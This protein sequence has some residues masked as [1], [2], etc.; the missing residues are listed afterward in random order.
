MLVDALY[1]ETVQAV[2]LADE[3]PLRLLQLTEEE[4][5]SCTFDEIFAFDRTVSRLLEMQSASYLNKA[6]AKSP[7]PR[8][9]LLTRL[10][11]AAIDA[12]ARFQSPLHV[13]ASLDDGPDGLAAVFREYNWG[14]DDLL[15]GESLRVLLLDLRAAL[16]TMGFA[17]TLAGSSTSTSDEALVE[18][19]HMSFQDF[20][21]L[22]RNL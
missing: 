11:A 5:L 3:V 1:E 6:S 10:Q 18:A 15:P 4:R 9:W 14:R 7:G 22:V 13:L 17:S 8:D 2:F 16:Q 12:S 21:K 20:R 19:E